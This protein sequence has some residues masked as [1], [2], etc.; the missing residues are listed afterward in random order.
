MICLQAT[1]SDGVSLLQFAIIE[2]NV[3]AAAKLY[4]NITFVALATLL[5]VDVDKVCAH[6][7]CRGHTVHCAALVAIVDPCGRM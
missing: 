7:C 1:N 4:H 5:N 3:Y 6:V 2:H